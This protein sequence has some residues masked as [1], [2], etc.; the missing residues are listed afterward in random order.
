MIPQEIRDIYTIKERLRIE[1]SNQVP[2]QESFQDVSCIKNK[3]LRCYLQHQ[4][5]S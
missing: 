2:I 4:T 5:R 1:T 3:A